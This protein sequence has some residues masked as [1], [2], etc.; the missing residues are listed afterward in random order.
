MRCDECETALYE[1]G[2]VVSAGAY[3]RVDDGSFRRVA[4]AQRGPLPPSF[5]G[6]VAQ[7][8]SAAASCACERRHA[9]QVALA[10]ARAIPLIESQSNL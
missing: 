3:V 9:A 10:P 8:R 7:Y 4:L 5:D 1:A 6:H 2:E